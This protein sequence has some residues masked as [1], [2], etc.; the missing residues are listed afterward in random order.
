[1]DVY[2][3]VH[4]EVGSLA[5]YVIYKPWLGG[6][7]RLYSTP[8]RG[9]RKSALNIPQAEGINCKLPLTSMRVLY[10]LNMLTSHGLYVS[11]MEAIQ[12]KG[13]VHCINSA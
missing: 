10:K 4:R 5:E 8:D 12:I 1:M 2:T 9:Q 7:L 6:A 3:Q 13:T 11:T